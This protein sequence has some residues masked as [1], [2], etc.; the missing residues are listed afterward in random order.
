MRGQALVTLLFFMIIGLTITSGAVVMMLVNSNAGTRLQEGEVAYQVAQSGAENGMIR[1]LRNPSY[2]G[3]TI[4]VGSGSATITKS[5]T[6][7][8]NDPYIITSTGTA[9]NFVRKVEVRATYV[10]NLLQVQSQK[11]I[12]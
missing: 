3:E 10:N 12:F 4:T 6:G 9:G 7:V 8:V 11:E 5:G 1:L 2:A